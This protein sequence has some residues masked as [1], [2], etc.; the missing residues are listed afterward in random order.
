[1][2]EEEDAEPSSKRA[3]IDDRNDRDR[4]KKKQRGQNK[5]RPLFKENRA[6]KLCRAL[7]DGMPG[8][9]MFPKCE[10]I[11]DVAEFF[12]RKPAELKGECFI[13]KTCGY[14]VNGLTCHYAK[15]HITDEFVNM[16][17]ESKES[18]KMSTFNRIDQDLLN[19]LRKKK[20]DFSRSNKIVDKVLKSVNISKNGHEKEPRAS[21]K[22]EGYVPDF[23]LIPERKCEKKTIDFSN[24]LLLSPLTTVGNLP[25]RRIC[26]EY[27]ADITCGEMACVVPLINGA[28]Q[29][30][31]LTKRH[32]SEDI[33]GVQLCGNKANL[34]SYATQ[35]MDEKFNVDFVDL[36][37]GCPIELIYQQ[38]AGSALIRR[39]NVLEGIVRSCATILGD[40]PFTV[41]T[42]T[43]VYAD[44]SVA[45]EL[46][47]KFE[48]WGASA[49]TVSKVLKL[50]QY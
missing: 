17:V 39:Q 25:F 27:G 3:K 50:I 41:K 31:A 10:F 30:W 35:L 29:E 36:N 12:R 14:C 15:S 18:T 5:S 20:Y 22:P 43:G 47:E 23:D 9:C 7:L 6:D 8:P 37:I 2:V 4:K 19:V 49:V 16:G 24:K 34:V 38:G 33:F 21:S 13:Y 42:R 48:K 11:H 40:K 1:M 28:K 46:V 44:K 45:H 26:K 32:E